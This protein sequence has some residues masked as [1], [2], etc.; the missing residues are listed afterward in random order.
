LANAGQDLATA[1]RQS[2]QAG[3]G[4]RILIDIWRPPQPTAL[5]HVFHGLAEHPARY[6]RFARHC[7]AQGLAV[8]AHNHR[9]H[10]ENCSEDE[11]GHY[12]DNDGWDHVISD[13]RLVQDELI[14][15]WPNIPIIL[16]GHSMGSYI[17]QSFLVRGHGSVSAL[18]LSASNFNMRAQLRI[19][20]W[21]AAFESVRGGKRN[22][23]K[24]LNK[25]AFGEFN[26]PFRPNRT[27]F[28]WL[29]RDENEVDKYVAD[30]LSGSDSSSRL[31]FDLTGG[32]LEV[33]SLQALRKIPVD[34]PVLITGG[35]V[36]PVGGRKGLTL[37]AKKYRESGHANTTL[38]IYECSRHE[39]L[40]ETN[41]DEYSKDLTGWITDAVLTRN[42]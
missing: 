13:A 15:Q 10:G 7:N 12:A 37:L 26:K 11:L 32:L 28:D 29:S 23:S 36:D 22:K 4:R 31:W 5:I 6:E 33:S 30:P 18:V 1:E 9:G 21:I 40:T 14:R 34:L 3:D 39:M 42:A 38:K 20:H 8:A 24:L 25:M 41:R 19:A 27:D 35:S 17:A 2:L 16:L